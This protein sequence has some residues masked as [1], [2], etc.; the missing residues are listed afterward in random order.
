MDN[1]DTDTSF[2]EDAAA[3][4]AADFLET[5][6]NARAIVREEMTTSQGPDPEGWWRIEIPG[7]YTRDGHP[8]PFTLPGGSADV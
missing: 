7:R 6:Q 8:L 4:Y 2:Y 1:T 5:P 3:E